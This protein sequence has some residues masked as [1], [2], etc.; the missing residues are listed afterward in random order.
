MVRA[1]AMLAAV[2]AAYPLAAEEEPADGSVARRYRYADGA[3][4][5]GVITAVSR[6]FCGGCTR[7]RLTADGKILHLPL[8]GA[9]TDLSP[10]LQPGEDL[11]LLRDAVRATWASRADRYSRRG[12]RR[13]PAA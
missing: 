10:L 13:R 5:L 11:R 1:A 7:L 2:D 9:G 3:G 12:P 4:V 8:R 6:P